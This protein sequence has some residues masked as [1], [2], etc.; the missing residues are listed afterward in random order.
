MCIFGH[1]SE[2]LGRGSFLALSRAYQIDMTDIQTVKFQ[3]PLTNSDALRDESND[4]PDGPPTDPRK[5][6]PLRYL[7]TRPVLISVANYATL[8][9]LGMVASSLMPLIWSTSIKFG[10]LDMSPAPTGAWLLVCGCMNGM[11]QFAIFP[12]AV[13]RVGPR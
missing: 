3:S 4:N 9:L 10:G 7:L 13:A 5:P 11:F 12:R 1:S 6:V 2:F 8:M